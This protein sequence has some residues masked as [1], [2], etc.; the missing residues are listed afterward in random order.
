MSRH[1]FN[2]VLWE[3]GDF[4]EKFLDLGIRSGLFVFLRNGKNPKTI[5]PSAFPWKNEVTDGPL[6]RFGKIHGILTWKIE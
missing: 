4:N 2:F 3:A 6:P 5:P 1:T